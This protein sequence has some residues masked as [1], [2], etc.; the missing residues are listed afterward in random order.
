MMALETTLRATLASTHP[1]WSLAMGRYTDRLDHS[2]DSAAMVQAVDARSIPTR[3]GEEG[4]VGGFQTSS[5]LKP[6]AKQAG[7]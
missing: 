5:P 2:L 4:K 7:N 6:A 1:D 3:R